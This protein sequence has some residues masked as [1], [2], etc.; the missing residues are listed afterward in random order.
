M[1]KQRMI[2]LAVGCLA[3][4]AVASTSAL[5]TLVITGG[6]PNLQ[7]VAAPAMASEL[8]TSKPK[9]MT[10]SVAPTTPSPRAS[11][12]TAASTTT[13]KPPPASRV[14][15]QPLT[16]VQITRWGVERESPKKTVKLD[17]TGCT[18]SN[19]LIRQD[20][21]RC[22]TTDSEVLDPCFEIRGGLGLMCP[23]APGS[24]EWILISAEG[25]AGDIAPPTTEGLP[26]A[27]E[28]ANGARCIQASGATGTVSGLRGSYYC[29]DGTWLYGD[30]SHGST[31]HIKLP[32]T[33]RN[34]SLHTVAI[35]RAWF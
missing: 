3:V 8:A 24:T 5:L 12:T 4:I 6:G 27:V 28:I 21:M 35:R 32:T 7:S 33:G 14:P 23:S 1:T 13:S 20:A 29:P 16:K 2:L 10:S 34:G 17:Q 22:F 25:N 31:W 26:W 11:A 15:P 18:E 30:P 9:P 19:L